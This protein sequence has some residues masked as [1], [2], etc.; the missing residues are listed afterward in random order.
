MKY[1]KQIR[2]TSCPKAHAADI[3]T[4]EH[5][6]ETTTLLKILALGTCQIEEGRV[7]PAAEVFKRIRERRTA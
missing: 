4:Y 1:A 6:Q 7:Q 5:P 2:P 3:G